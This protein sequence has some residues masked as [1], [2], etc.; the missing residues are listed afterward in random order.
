MRGTAAYYIEEGDRINTHVLT[1]RRKPL[2]A[3]LL[4][5]IRYGSKLKVRGAL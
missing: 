5:G 1:V 4:A 2:D 3:K